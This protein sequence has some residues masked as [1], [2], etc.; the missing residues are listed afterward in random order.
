[1]FYSFYVREKNLENI[2]MA[3]GEKYLENIM[4]SEKN[5]SYKI[6]ILQ[7]T[8]YIYL[9]F[10][11]SKYLFIDEPA[12]Y[13]YIACITFDKY[14]QAKITTPYFLEYYGRN[15]GNFQN[16]NGNIFQKTAPHSI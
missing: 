15:R 2:I 5:N 4:S 14:N 3:F 10:V 7:I 6:Y 13:I 12:G 8:D 16:N 11:V 9:F 1:M